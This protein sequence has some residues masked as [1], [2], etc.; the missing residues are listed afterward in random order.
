MNYK[1]FLK[2]KSFLDVKTGFEVE[3]NSLNKMLFDWQKIIV[4]WSIAKGRSAI[5][6]GCGLGK[7][8]IQLEWANKV[9]RK[10]KEPILILAPLAVSEQT[11]REGDKFGIKVN[12]CSSHE[13]V[14]NGIN[15]TNYEKLHKFNPKDFIGIV[16]DES[17]II[18]SFS[19]QIRNQII[20]LFNKTEYRLA[21][22]ATPSPNDYMELGNHAEFL[23]VMTR[24]EMLSMF[25]INDTKDTGIWRLK[26]HVKNNVFWEWMSL[27]AVMLTKPSDIGYDD[28]DF[29]LPKIHYYEHI[30]KTNVKP[31]RGFFTERAKTLN[32]RRQVRKETINVRSEDAAKL[33]N[34]TDDGWIV[35]CNLNNEGD[36][37][38]KKINGAVQVAG[39]D[40]NEIK[41]DRMV[42]F[43][44]GKIKRLVTK[45]KIGGFG[46]N[47]QVCF[48]A[49]F[50][51][52]SDSWEQW[53]QA[54]RRIWRFGQTHEVYIHMF[55]E[56]R[57]G[58]VLD[59]IKRKDKQACE[60]IEN[61]IEYMSDLSKH[62]LRQISKETIDYIPIIK[63]RLPKW[64]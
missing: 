14:V 51:G 37:L 52:L 12:I 19:G 44:S 38:E 42:N 32:D 28:G 29:I 26:G 60:M 63:M 34:S 18:K 53:F 27:W 30:I 55:I 50:V 64:F 20:E 2:T 31:K 36:V 1:S 45:P 57:E 6:A 43:A 48:N 17:S 16:L 13:D 23:G 25:F 35:W 54:I 33:I 3:L 9:Y 59:N 39:K 58:S 8:P 61:M 40:S 46:M 10:T 22:T 11:K 24:S 4:R 49:A 41:V 62:E 7:T 56:E 15:I 5:F 21:C 47:W